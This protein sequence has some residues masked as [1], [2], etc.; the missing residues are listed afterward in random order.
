MSNFRVTRAALARQARALA[1]P[2]GKCQALQSRDRSRC[3]FVGSTHRDVQLQN[4]RN[5]ISHL[6]P[7]PILQQP[8]ILGDL[9]RVAALYCI[10]FCNPHFSLRCPLVSARPSRST[11]G[12]PDPRQRGC[13][14]FPESPLLAFAYLRTHNPASGTRDRSQN[15]FALRFHQFGRDLRADICGFP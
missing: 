6:L 8:S 2:S 14:R 10:L 13:D 12:L 4:T 7:T 1:P 5:H 3:C 9:C 11:S 15:N